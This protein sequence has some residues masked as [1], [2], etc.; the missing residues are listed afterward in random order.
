MPREGSY[1]DVTL[2]DTRITVSNTVPD[3]RLKTI[4]Y[5]SDHRGIQ[6]N[7]SVDPSL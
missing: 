4:D 7:I 6:F 1:L 2:R 3:G 5:D